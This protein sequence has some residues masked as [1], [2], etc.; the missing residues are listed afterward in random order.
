MDKE[1]SD[2]FD[3]S[4]AEVFDALSS[5]QTV[6]H[7]RSKFAV[8]LPRP[9]AV[10]A[11]ILI[12]LIVVALVAIYQQEEISNL[13]RQVGSGTVEID[14]VRYWDVTVPN[15]AN[16]GTYVTL[17][18]VNFTYVNP[19]PYFDSYSNPANFTYSGSV[20]V[21][22]GTLLNLTG[23]SV[24]IQMNGGGILSDIVVSF[25]GGQTEVYGRYTLTAVN[26]PGDQNIP[27]RYVLLNLT[28]YLPPV[29]PWFTVHNAPRAGI[30][31]NVTSHSL[32]FYAG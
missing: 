6:E 5:T 16:N 21:S 23:K 19:Q 32:I 15:N 8:S 10:L 7:A 28:D 4:K 18:G 25:P 27:H 26:F 31:W 11:V 17:H 3:S 20:R 30:F 12:A 29:N 9:K 14:G 2:S 1:P 13:N 22:N 24:E